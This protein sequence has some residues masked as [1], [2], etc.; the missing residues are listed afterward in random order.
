MNSRWSELQKRPMSRK[1]FLRLIGIGLLVVANL[2]AIYKLFH[3][4]TSNVGKS[5]A[6]GYGSSGY[7]GFVGKGG[8]KRTGAFD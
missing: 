1:E 4:G 5:I 8:S 7:G 6:S 2:D 3:H